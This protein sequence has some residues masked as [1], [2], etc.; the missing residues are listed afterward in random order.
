MSLL[1]RGAMCALTL[2]AV[3]GACAKP[4]SAP[5]PTPVSASLYIRLGGYDAIAAVTDDFLRRIHG[6][7]A[8]KPFFLGLE[9]PQLDRIRQMVVDQLCAASGGPCVYVGKS[10]KDAHA[11]LDIPEATFDRFIGHFQATLTGFKVPSREQNEV[12]GALLSMK[13]DVVA[14]K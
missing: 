7:T 8:I 3:A 12:M 1:R 2:L 14:R 5:V 13:A 10:M 6:D 4:A 11:T 9:K